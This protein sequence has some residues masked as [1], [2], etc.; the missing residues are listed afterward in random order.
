MIRINRPIRN[1]K[2]TVEVSEGQMSFVL[3]NTFSGELREE[4][5][6]GLKGLNPFKRLIGKKLKKKKKKKIL[7][8]RGVVHLSLTSLKG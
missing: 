2:R 5:G 4:K 1:E 3:A 6:K 7:M 8:G